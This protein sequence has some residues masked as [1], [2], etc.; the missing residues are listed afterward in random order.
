MTKCL[1]KNI[2]DEPPTCADCG[3]YVCASCRVTLVNPVGLCGTCADRK[4]ITTPEKCEAILREIVKRCNNSQETTEATV[5]FGPD[6]W[7]GNALTVY[8]DGSHT[9]VGYEEAPFDLL[10]NNLYDLL[11]EGK[12]LSLAIPMP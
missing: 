6:A 2:T 1:H 12:G 9:H 11:I 8:L 5:G 3:A 10:I 7:G 4:A